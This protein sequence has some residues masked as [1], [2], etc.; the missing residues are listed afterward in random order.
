MLPMKTCPRY[1][2]RI[3]FGELKIGGVFHNDI[4][5]RLHQNAA[6][7]A[8]FYGQLV[9]TPDGAFNGYGYFLLPK[10]PAPGQ[11]MTTAPKLS[12][13]LLLSAP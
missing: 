1:W 6:R 8:I 11:T 10:P 13:A 4:S 2:L 7:K 5:F 9:Q 3:T 12:G